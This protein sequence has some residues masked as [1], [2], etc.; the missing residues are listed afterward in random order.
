[1]ASILSRISTST[2][3]APPPP[4]TSQDPTTS[5]PLINFPTSY[6]VGKSQ[7]TFTNVHELKLHLK[8]LAAFHQLRQNVEADSGGWAGRL[9][10]KARWSCFVN[11]AVGRLADLVKDMTG[12]YLDPVPVLP[13]DVML[14]LHAYQL[15]PGRYEEDCLRSIPLLGRLRGWVLEHGSKTIE[16]DTLAQLVDEA[17]ETAW[18]RL[19]KTCFDP[20]RNFTETKGC[21]VLDPKTSTSYTMPWINEEGTGYAQQGFSFA[22]PRGEVWTHEWLGILKLAGDMYATHD[23]PA[24]VLAGTIQTPYVSTK[25]RRSM[26]VAHKVRNLMPV[27]YSSS[28]HDLANMMGGNRKGARVTLTLALGKKNQKG[29]DTILSCYTRGEPF[30][31]DLAMAVLRQ[32]TFIDKV[33]NLGWLDPSRFESDDTLLNRSVARYHAFMDLLSSSSSMFCVPTLD[34]DLAWHTHQLTRRYDVDICRYVGRFVDHDDKVE[35]NALAT[36]F[37]NTARAWQVRFGVPYFSCGCPPPPP[38]ASLS[39][40]TSRLSS[41]QSSAF[42]PGTLHPLPAFRSTL[43]SNEAQATHASEHNSLYLPNYSEAKKK[44]DKR[45]L[46]TQGRRRKE[47]NLRRGK[48]GSQAGAGHEVAFLA[49]V[50]LAATYGPVGYPIP[51]GGCCSFSGNTAG[52]TSDSVSS[53]GACALVPVHPAAPAVRP[54]VVVGA[55]APQAFAAAGGP[56]EMVVVGAVEAGVEAVADVVEAVGAAGTEAQ[57]SRRIVEG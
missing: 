11:V 52:G 27:K 34:I 47:Q 13:L 31:L 39:R 54:P 1:M 29:V 4:Y 5:P 25:T 6:H 12:S 40:L 53:G 9:E 48:G 22:G 45:M 49:A 56:E 26:F 17:D 41:R 10:P 8:V 19:T 42:P 24:C 33:H 43:D 2:S 23:F 35:E 57:A 16:E 14:V 38:P 28:A 3:E 18:L 20:Y 44:R 21:V 46:E 50:P 36:G 32:G 37:D 51:A 30:S 55:A 7:A 15:N